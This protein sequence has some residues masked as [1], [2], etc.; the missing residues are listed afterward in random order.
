MAMITARRL[1][2]SSM[3]MKL[4]AEQEL[5]RVAEEAAERQAAQ[6]EINDTIRFQY[7]INDIALKSMLDT[8]AI[9]QKM[10]DHAKEMKMPVASVV[11]ILEGQKESARVRKEAAIER[12]YLKAV[13]KAVKKHKPVFDTPENIENDTLTLIALGKEESRARA[14]EI[15]KEIQSE[16]K[17]PPTEVL[18]L[19]IGEPKSPGKNLGAVFSEVQIGR[20]VFKDVGEVVQGIY[21]G[22]VGGRTTMAEKRM[23]MGIA[24]MHK[25]LSDRAASK[26]GNAIVNVKID[27]EMVHGTATLTLIGSGD[28]VKMTKS[29]LAKVKVKANPKRKVKWYA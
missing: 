7:L 10:Y 23:A 20:N 26:G 11:R 1:L 29:S 3:E 17:N 21:R 12:A 4:A 2:F 8:G 5:R 28:A 16:K 24:A 6:D 15:W 22:L 27:Y 25:E 19:F 18:P 9:S 14:K 13:K